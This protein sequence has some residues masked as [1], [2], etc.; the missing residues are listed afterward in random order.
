[1]R[2]RKILAA[3]A[4]AIAGLAGSAGIAAA[5]GTVHA[6]ASYLHGGAGQDT[7]QSYLHG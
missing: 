1:M 5:T 6:S 7:P 4:I 3:A 2:I